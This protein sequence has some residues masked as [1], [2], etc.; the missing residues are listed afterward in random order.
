MG[1]SDSATVLGMNLDAVMG[2]NIIFQKIISKI[3]FL[4]ISLCWGPSG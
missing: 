3:E 4:L 2:G 1:H